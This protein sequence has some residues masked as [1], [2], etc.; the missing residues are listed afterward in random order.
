MNSTEAAPGL[1]TST[2][3]HLASLLDLSTRLSEADAVDVLNV[4]I[5][6]VMGRL[7]IHRACCLLP[8]H[9]G[10]AAEPRLCKGVAPFSVS[11]VAFNGI[12]HPDPSNAALQPII[13]AG[14]FTVVPVQMGGSTTAVLCF[15]YAMGGGEDDPVVQTYLE[16]VRA[17][18][19]TTMHNT[20]LFRSLLTA[21]KELEARNLMVTTLFESAR[22][23]T[24]PKTKEELLRILSYRLM[25][26]LMVSTFGVFLREPLNDVDL[27]VN[28]KDASTLADIHP[29]MIEIDRPIRFSDLDANDPLRLTA[30]QHGIALAAP[31]TVHGVKKGVIATKAKLNAREFTDEELSFLEALGNTAMTAIE[32]ERLIQ[33]EMIKHRIEGELQIA[34]DIQRKLLPEHLPQFDRFEVAADARTSRQIGGDYYDVVKLDE[35]RTL[36]AIADVSG[37]GVPAALVMANVQAALNVLARLELTLS[38]LMERINSLVC[39]NTEPGVFVTMFVLVLNHRT[40]AIEYVNAGHNPPLLWHNGDVIPLTTGGVLTGVIDDPPPYQIGTGEIH[41]GDCLVLYTDGVTEAKQ[42]ID[43]YGVERLVGIVSMHRDRSAND[44]IDIVLKDIRSF[45]D[46]DALDDDTS[47]VVVRAR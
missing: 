26:Q 19:G 38:T 1:G 34:A 44:I 36:F 30:E 5:L 46:T 31:M 37:K 42:G 32:N 10:W 23:F 24:G 35:D 47:L 43:E 33:S 15:G 27:I 6:S 21:T 29:T 13:D 3:F 16:L 12:E 41:A 45:T 25:G 18:V 28:R 17:I 9:A 7:K 2:A 22:D 4:A 14:L 11:A 40:G 39:M 20:R 8:D